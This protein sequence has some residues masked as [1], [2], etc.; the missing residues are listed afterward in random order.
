M[1]DVNA[2]EVEERKKLDGIIEQQYREA[3]NLD[4]SKRKAEED[5]QIYL[6]KNRTLRHEIEELVRENRKLTQEK[7]GLN[8]RLTS[9]RGHNKQLEKKVR[10]D[11]DDKGPKAVKRELM[12]A[13]SRVKDLE[14]WAAELED[15]LSFTVDKFEEQNQRF[16]ECGRELAES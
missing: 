6:V 9:L 7:D 16:M 8:S 12:E 14:E 3:M 10:V 5:R 1:K 4:Q 13:Q 15:K 2:R 11:T